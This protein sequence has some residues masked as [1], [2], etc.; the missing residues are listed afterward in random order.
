MKKIGTKNWVIVIASFLTQA[1]YANIIYQD[2]FSTNGLLAGRA[3]EIGSGTWLGSVSTMITTNGVALPGGDG[4]QREV[5]LA[6]TPEAGKKY[7]LSADV[8]ITS[9][10]YVALGFLSEDGTITGNKFFNEVIKT[11][12]PWMLAQLNGIGK[13]YVQGTSTDSQSHSGVGSDVTMKIVLDTTG[14]DWIATYYYDD[15]AV[16]TYTYSGALTITHV[17]LG[18]YSVSETTVDNFK[19]EVIPEPGSVSLIVLSSVGLMLFRRR[20]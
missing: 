4:Y 11:P 6:F 10:S 12:A 17:G 5:A 20:M 8:T 15:V 13:T 1:V 16:R 19:L 14:T 18:A 7:V 3:V 2:T 9:G